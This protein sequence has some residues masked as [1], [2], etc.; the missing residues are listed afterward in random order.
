MKEMVG[1][2]CVCSDEHGWAENPLVYCDG[3]NCSVA[4]HQ[5]CYGIVCVPTGPWFCRKCE[6]QER[7]A[8]VRCELCPSKNG[9]LKKTDN[10]GWAH[11]VCALYIPEVRFG[12]VTTM[13]PII[14]QL[15]P[16]ERYH[17]PCYICQEGGKPTR[18]TIG[19]CMQC[20]KSGCKQQFHV[21]CAQTLGL[22]CEE[23]GNYLDN[24]KYC[25]YCQHHYSK[26]KFQKKGGNV[27]TIPPYK[28]IT[29]ET[30]SSDP[31]SSPEKESFS[32][33]SA[34][35]LPTTIASSS[36]TIL[37]TTS[38]LSSTTITST[39]STVNS[40]KTVQPVT[41]I[42]SGSS[43]STK[44]RKSSNTSKSLTATTTINNTITI[45]T[46]NSTS[47][48]I[49]QP[50]VNLSNSSVT[51]SIKNSS[52]SSSGSNSSSAKDKDKH[53][54]SVSSKISGSSKG[55]S[56]DKEISSTRE[57]SSKR[58][59][60]D[61]S[62]NSNSS[63][64]RA[65]DTKNSSIGGSSSSSSSRSN[66]NVTMASVKEMTIKDSSGVPQKFTT[67]NFTESIVVN[68]DSV[69][70][71]GDVVSVPNSNVKQTVA[72]AKKRK[73]DGSKN[74]S[75]N[76]SLD[77]VDI[78]KDLIKDVSV[79]LVPL[80]SEEMDPV[81][82]PKTET[83]PQILQIVNEPNLQNVNPTTIITS[84]NLPII[85]Q[86]QQQQPQKQ[87]QHSQQQTTVILNPALKTPI[88]KDVNDERLQIIPQ[89]FSQTSQPS[90]VVSVPLAQATA[91][92]GVNLPLTT[93][94]NLSA[95]V[96]PTQS[97][98][99]QQLSQ[100]RDSV[101][102]TSPIVQLP[103]L[104][105]HQNPIERQSP[106]IQ[107]TSSPS[108]SIGHHISHPDHS[109][110]NSQSSVVQ[111]ISPAPQQIQSASIVGQ[112]DGGGGGGLKIAFEK[113]PNSRIAQLSQEDLP[114]RRSSRSQS[115]ESSSIK[116][117]RT[118][119]KRAVNSSSPSA[120][121]SSSSS[122]FNE[123]L[124]NH[125]LNILAAVTQQHHQQQ[126]QQQH[127]QQTIITAPMATGGG[128]SSII[129][130]HTN[131][132]STI[133]KKSTRSNNNL[134]QTNDVSPPSTSR[135]PETSYTNISYGGGLKFTYEAQPNP[136]ALAAAAAA[137]QQQSQMIV[138]DSPPSS[139]GSEAGSSSRKRGRK[140]DDLK[141][142]KVFQNGV[143]ASHMLG[144]QL[145]PSSS[146]AQKMSDQLNMEMEQSAY[147]SSS[148]DS[149]PQ[150]IGPPF[151][152][153]NTTHSTAH[154]PLSQNNPNP[155]AS[156]L[157]GAGSSSGTL[158]QSLE[159]LLERQWEQ[160]SQFLM[161][162]A[163]HFDIASLLSCLHQL[164]AEN[165]RLEED[166]NNLV[167]RRDHLLAV[168]A[169]LAI[170]LSSSL[171]QQPAQQQV[172]NNMHI[173]GPSTNE[174]T[175]NRNN[176]SRE[177]GGN[178]GVGGGNPGSQHFNSQIPPIE[179]GI[180]FRHTTSHNPS[181][182]NNSSSARHSSTSFTSTHSGSNSRHSVNLE[183]QRIRNSG[184]SF[185]I[186]PSAYSQAHQQSQIRPEDS[187]VKPS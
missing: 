19:A 117:T 30:G 182:G 46:T 59:S 136:S 129:N 93:T 159:Q 146:V 25:G 106:L 133:T 145:N 53:S 63:S 26:L 20:N 112:L 173:N 94:V 155:L 90:L 157:S 44:Q 126:Q 88:L 149:G 7:S 99:F 79:T 15:I 107:Q 161:E 101:S 172:F 116:S 86:Q 148:L 87:Q 142:I 167:T 168:N 98:L 72:V 23:A 71:G 110:S 111:S 43:S 162:Q 1:G 24:V 62:T 178:S 83:T 97:A 81:K 4:V 163:Q 73:A 144:N 147:T 75:A 33:G 45:S 135:T 160:G 115:G 114:A 120:A 96:P 125:S 47:T 28:P 32:S 118:S 154:P 12:N 186:Q 74:S 21:T 183:T 39:L 66:S 141:D 153:K 171:P 9:A 16:N 123:N 51:N 29:H 164:R 38:S 169:R 139:P 180:D 92:A 67:S 78:N 54:K 50:T 3:S 113:Q 109:S 100:S 151:P 177:S 158:H 48:A 89:N 122:T 184:S 134:I 56:G 42:S 138:K 2:C 22:L 69:F 55:H 104:H 176:R 166:V 185:Q 102:R 82:K 65:P 41:I 131:I 128:V 14:L 175:S 10:Q 150:L 103:Q 34:A 37:A 60:K 137:A 140:S 95:A 132:Q 121:S 108:P 130:N 76:S 68:S 127:Q 179:N 49:Q 156:M 174:T 6:S 52:T 58:N 181:S 18:A 124:N 105:N 17:K 31:P 119:K 84:G 143:L 165:V 170:P 5:A 152:G 27:K 36:S 40:T 85:K 57:K 91:V 35:V 64:S 61:D 80:T 13:E 8:R 187:Q 11:V 70:G 77:T